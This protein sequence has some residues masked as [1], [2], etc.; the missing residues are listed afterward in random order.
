LGGTRVMRPMCAT[1]QAAGTAA[2]IALKYSTTPRGVY[3]QHIAELQ[4]TLLKDGCYLPGTKNTD[5]NDLALSA[6]ATASSTS[7][8]V[9]TAAANVNNGWNR[10]VDGNRNAW[11]PLIDA[12]GPHWVQLQLPAAKDIDTVHVTFE[13]QSEAC[14]VQVMDGGVWKTVA[15]VT[16]DNTRRKVFSIGTVKTDRVRLLGDVIFR[17][18]EM[19]LYREE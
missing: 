17:V 5:T 14:Q 16:A 15:T 1:G 18:C 4:Q 19:R 2:V 11:A 3:D 6:T 7:T 12:A 8:E 10:V 9:G 13:E